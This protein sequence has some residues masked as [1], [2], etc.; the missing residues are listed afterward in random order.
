MRYLTVDNF[1]SQ[2]KNL[3]QEFDGRFR[4]PLYTHAERFLWDY[5]HV[6]GE[7]THLRTPA[8]NYFPRKMYEPFH[9]YLV[10][11]GREFLGC[12]DVSPPWLSCY[13][14]GCRQFPHQDVPHGPLA[15]VFS[16]TNWKNKKFRGGET[17]LTQPKEL[18]E[19]KFNRLT[20]FN[21][22]I[23]H[24]VREVKGTHD[25]R[26]GRL[27]IH[28]W[29]VNPRPF[30]VGPLTASDV[31]KALDRGLAQIP[32]GAIDLGQGFGAFRLKIRADGRVAEIAQLIETFQN[33]SRVKKL[34]PFLAQLEFRKRSKG[35]LLTLPLRID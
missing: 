28:G 21:P 14:D 33:S 7:Y 34:L 1:Y 11:W 9:R 32:F 20:L 17:F 29:F 23:T 22:A 2:A 31:G 13:V 6:P 27:V 10:Q 25:P 5:W 30:W 35:S 3:R 19:P 15:F 4:N 26:E 12:H 18:I 24:G 16:L 8:Y